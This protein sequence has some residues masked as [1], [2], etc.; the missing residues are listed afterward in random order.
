[1]LITRTR[2]VTRTRSTMCEM[3]DTNKSASVRFGQMLEKIVCS[4][5]ANVRKD[6][7]FEMGECS[8]SGNV[9][10]GELWT[11]STY[12]YLFKYVLVDFG[13]SPSSVCLMC[14]LSWWSC[15]M[16]CVLC[17]AVVHYRYYPC[18]C[19]FNVCTQSSAAELSVIHE[20]P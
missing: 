18:L 15:C 16:H 5:W 17:G 11:S 9:L 20:C 19:T 3:R 10:N 8:K 6:R 4:I 13:V 1:M 14:N 12:P 7:V 2:A